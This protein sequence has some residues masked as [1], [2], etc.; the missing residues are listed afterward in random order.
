M[1]APNMPFETDLRKRASPVAR[2]LNGVVLGFQAKLMVRRFKVF[3]VFFFH[4]AAASVIFPARRAKSSPRRRS[5]CYC[6]APKPMSNESH[7]EIS[8]REGKSKSDRKL[9]AIRNNLAKA[10][11]ALAAKRA[12]RAAEKPAPT[13]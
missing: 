8:A 1:A 7:S 10:K 5:F 13:Q 12:A 9:T 11:A 6:E 3:Y 2:P 4:G